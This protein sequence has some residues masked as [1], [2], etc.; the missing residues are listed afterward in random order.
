MRTS[1][2]ISFD[3]A[4]ITAK[5]DSTVTAANIQSFTNP[6]SLAL[7]GVY[8]TKAA[9]LEE[10]YWKLDGTFEVFPDKPQWYTWG[11]WSSELSG[12]DG[13]FAVPIVLTITFGELHSVNGIGFEFNPHDNSY[14]SDM[15]VIFYNGETAVNTL[16]L[17]P[18]EWR[19]S[20]DVNVENFNKIEIK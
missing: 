10:N 17:T 15:T 11:I 20:Y 1:V 12:E 8:A 2:D 3:M 4:D 5:R 16:E 19:Y 14:C 9:T 13:T 7:D 6:D 18:D